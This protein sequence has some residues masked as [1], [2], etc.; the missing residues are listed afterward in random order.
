VA[1]G[2]GWKGTE[3]DCA[4]GTAVAEEGEAEVLF[5]KSTARVL[6]ADAGVV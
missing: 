6:N 1:A 5:S 3:A 2:D 4:E